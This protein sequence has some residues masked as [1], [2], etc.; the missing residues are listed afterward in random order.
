MYMKVFLF[1]FIMKKASS[2]RD[3]R[4]SNKFMFKVEQNKVEY[5]HKN[6]DKENFLMHVFKL[7]INKG[8][9]E[10]TYNKIIIKS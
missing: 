6:T 3:F 9:V 10:K 5:W 7:N 8:F 1:L 4:D 2:N